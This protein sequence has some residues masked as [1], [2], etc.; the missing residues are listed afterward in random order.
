M[1][2]KCERYYQKQWLTRI[3]PSQLSIFTSKVTTNNGAESYHAKLNNTFKCNHPN[4]WY[5]CDTLNKII[6]DTDTDITRLNNGLDISR[7]QKRIQIFK[8]DL[9]ESCR[10]NLG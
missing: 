2:K 1:N 10:R 8:E 5:F 4:I 9:R 6:T 7:S 3:G